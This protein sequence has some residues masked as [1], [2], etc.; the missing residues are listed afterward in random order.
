MGQRPCL[1]GLPVNLPRLLQWSVIVTMLDS[2]GKP[3]Y[4][5]APDKWKL[6]FSMRLRLNETSRRK[7]ISVTL[8]EA[9]RLGDLTRSDEKNEFDRIEKEVRELTDRCRNNE[10]EL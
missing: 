1:L 2:F 9:L 8:M 5:S 10:K 6:T 7:D 4:R 3:N